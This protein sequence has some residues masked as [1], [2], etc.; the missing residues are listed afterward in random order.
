M[1]EI[2]LPGII[3]ALIPVYPGTGM[4][5]LKQ[6]ANDH[7]LADTTKDENVSRKGAKTAKKKCGTAAI[8]CLP[9]LVKNIRGRRFHVLEFPERH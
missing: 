2:F 1:P 5:F 6:Q 3:F 7:F 9:G 4:H 8:P